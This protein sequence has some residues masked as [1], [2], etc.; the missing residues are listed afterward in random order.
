ML[1]GAPRF[2]AAYLMLQGR[3]RRK[4]KRGVEHTTVNPAIE[5]WIAG[6]WARNTTKKL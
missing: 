6:S 3:S 1:V 4:P 2:P 5:A